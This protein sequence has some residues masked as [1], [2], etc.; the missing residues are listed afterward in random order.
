LEN[1]QKLAFAQKHLPLL[2]RAATGL[3]AALLV[4]FVTKALPLYSADWRVLTFLL[5]TALW[6]SRPAV[7]KF[8]A[9]A[10]CFLPIAYL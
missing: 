6:I 9:L 5:V 7:G 4:V 1:V 8:V 2:I 10:V 3:M